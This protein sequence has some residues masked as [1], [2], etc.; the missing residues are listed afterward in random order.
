[1]K[2]QLE[3]ELQ[4]SIVSLTA[5]CDSL[6]QCCNDQALELFGRRQAAAALNDGIVKVL[7]ASE[8][9]AYKTIELN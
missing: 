5:K 2:I 4:R 6:L 7:R 9:R 1:L 8:K 3:E